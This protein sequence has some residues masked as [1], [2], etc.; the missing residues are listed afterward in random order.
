MMMIIFT[1][2]VTFVVNGA[3]YTVDLDPKYAVLEATTYDRCDPNYQFEAMVRFTD[4]MDV[5]IVEDV[6]AGHIEMQT[7]SL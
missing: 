7:A 6:K 1:Q 2:H 3:E 5:L 4:V